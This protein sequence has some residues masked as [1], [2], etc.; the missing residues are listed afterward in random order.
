MSEKI[1]ITFKRSVMVYK[2]GYAP[3]IIRLQPGEPQ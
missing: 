3:Q 2:R 1:V